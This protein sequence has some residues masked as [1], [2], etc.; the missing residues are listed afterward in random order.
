MPYFKNG[1]QHE[2]EALNNELRINVMQKDPIHFE[3]NEV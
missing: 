3:I 1:T 2:K